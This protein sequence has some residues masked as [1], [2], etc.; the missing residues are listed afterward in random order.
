MPC[1]VIAGQRTPGACCG[2]A[3]DAG[4]E[5]LCRYSFT[6]TPHFP[7]ISIRGALQ[8]D[9]AGLRASIETRRTS[10]GS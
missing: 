9:G 2:D 5:T 3:V 6:K 8:E 10:T 7:L 4:F 1:A